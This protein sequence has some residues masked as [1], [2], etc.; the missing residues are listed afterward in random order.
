MKTKKETK[1]SFLSSVALSSFSLS[2]QDTNF[3]DLLP[4]SSLPKAWY[5]TMNINFRDED[6]LT[7]ITDLL[8]KLI[9]SNNGTLRP[10]PHKDLHCSVLNIFTAPF[11]LDSDNK[12]NLEKIVKKKKSN[13][14]VILKDILQEKVKVWFDFLYFSQESIA[15]QVFFD[16]G[17]V[18][19]VKKIQESLKPELVAGIPNIVFENKLKLQKETWGA[20]NLIRYN[21]ENLSPFLRN[22][23]SNTITLFNREA[24]N[25]EF[26]TTALIKPDLVIS[27]HLFDGKNGSHIIFQG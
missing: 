9:C 4:V 20:M 16:E 27:D 8:T 5:L 19:K 12:E 26:L 21:S 10:Q 22:D 6:P 11:V 14:W 2:P 3:C 17:F 25:R 7:K 15:L 1:E 18:A 13:L 24:N 23:L